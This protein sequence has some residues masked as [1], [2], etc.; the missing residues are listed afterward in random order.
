[1]SAPLTTTFTA[2]PGGVP[3]VD[4]G[5]ITG[6]LELESTLADGRCRHRVRYAGADEWYRLEGEESPTPVGDATDLARLHEAL[7]DFLRA[8]EGESS[9]PVDPPHGSQRGRD[10]DDPAAGS[11]GGARRG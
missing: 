2:R 7:V 10:A 3:T 11:F 4:V 1:M 5:T 9:E 8:V 6:E